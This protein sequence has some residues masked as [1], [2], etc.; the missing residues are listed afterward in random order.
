M[1]RS[2]QVAVPLLASAALTLLSACKQMQMKRCVDARNVV[3][4]DAF[5]D[6]QSV[7]QPN[8]NNIGS[9][10]WYYGGTGNYYPGSTASGGGYAPASGFSYATARGGF[11]SSF[12]GGHGA[13]D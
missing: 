6:N 1:K 10:R 12:S 4:D 3:V 5:C 11:G 7:H 8:N 2:T 13:T 9:F